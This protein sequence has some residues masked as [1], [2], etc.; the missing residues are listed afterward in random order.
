[1]RYSFSSVYSTSSLKGQVVTSQASVDKQTK[2]SEPEECTSKSAFSIVLSLRGV[3]QSVNDTAKRPDKTKGRGEQRVTEATDE[4]RC[5]GHVVVLEVVTVGALE[6]QSANAESTYSGPTYLSTVEKVQ[7]VLVL[8]R[9]GR[10]LCRVGVGG[11]VTKSSSLT[12]AR[13]PHAM[14]N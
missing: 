5:E 8:G 14:P 9:G 11:R 10:Q 1:M 12:E 7:L 4:Q 6:V 13:A 3:A 2:L